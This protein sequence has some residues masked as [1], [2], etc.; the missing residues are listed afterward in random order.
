MDLGICS[1]PFC[2]PSSTC[3]LFADSREGRVCLDRDRGDDGSWD[4]LGS[5]LVPTLE[6]LRI[7][8]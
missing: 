5:F 4:L 3:R 7:S 8:L 1:A 6:G 2:N